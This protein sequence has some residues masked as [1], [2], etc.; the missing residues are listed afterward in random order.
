M[1]IRLGLIVLLMSLLSACSN[2]A[3]VGDGKTTKVSR[4]VDAFS[5]IEVQGHIVLSF[6]QAKKQ[7]VEVEAD[8]N[9]IPVVLTSVEKGVLIISMNPK[10]QFSTK[11]PVTVNIQAPSLAELTSSGANSVAMTNLNLNGL[12]VEFNGAGQGTFSGAVS[13]VNFHVVGTSRIQAKNLQ[14]KDAKVSVVGAGE[15]GLSVSDYLT[16]DISGVGHVTYFGDPKVE[17]KVYGLGQLIQGE[18]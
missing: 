16:V 7:S 10:I 8:S 9:I 15:V 18:S 1:R 14:T 17:K 3:V 6:K 11:N 5:R 2:K 13:E 12:S 4:D